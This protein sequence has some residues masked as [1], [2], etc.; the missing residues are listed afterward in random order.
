MSNG[1][2]GFREYRYSRENQFNFSKMKMKL[3]LAKKFDTLHGQIIWH[4][5]GPE[6]YFAF[7]PKFFDTMAK[8]FGDRGQVFWRSWPNYLAL[9]AKFFG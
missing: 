7:W 6:F 9:L 2:G 8:L 4:R 3:R 1:R 5:T